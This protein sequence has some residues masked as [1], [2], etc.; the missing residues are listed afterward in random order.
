MCVNNKLLWLVPLALAG[1]KKNVVEAENASVAEVAAKIKESGALKDTALRPGQWEA[2]IELRNISAPGIPPEMEQ[3]MRKGIG[4][5]KTMTEC[6]TEE[7]AKKP[8]DRFIEGYDKSCRYN[9]FTMGSG[10]IDT[11]ITCSNQGMQREMSMQGT[12]TPETYDLLMDSNALGGGKVRRVNMT[13]SLQA[14]RVG[15]CTKKQG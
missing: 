10:K 8:F 7:L 13:M 6:L 9:H 14:R 11:K 12:Y 4:R 3:E 2:K 15:E 1:C 5:S